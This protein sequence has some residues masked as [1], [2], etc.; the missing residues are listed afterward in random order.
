[1]NRGRSDFAVADL[2]HH[3]DI[4]ILA[5][6]AAQTLR[7]CVAFRYLC[8][9]DPLQVVFDRVFDRNYLDSGPRHGLE[10]R[11]ECRRLTGAGRTRVQYHAVR[12][13]DFFEEDLHEVLVETEI[14]KAESDR[15]RVEYAH[16][17]RFGIIARQG[18]CTDLDLF[19]VDVDAEAPGLR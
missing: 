5:Q 1:M 13:L 15:R 18:R 3:D 7:E 2:A 19:L 14:I 11:I 4:W 6:G 10:E 8:L 12:T 17:D 9:H 16:D